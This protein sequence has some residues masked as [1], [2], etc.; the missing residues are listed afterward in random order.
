MASKSWLL[1]LKG[2]KQ[3]SPR[4]RLARM[5]P[6]KIVNMVENQHARGCFRENAWAP[7]NYNVK[8]FWKIIFNSKT[9]VLFQWLLVNNEKIYLIPYLPLWPDSK[10]P[11]VPAQNRDTFWAWQ[12]GLP[13]PEMLPDPF[14]TQFI[15][16]ALLHKTAINILSV[17]T[18]KKYSQIFFFEENEE[19]KQH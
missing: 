7:R 3:G 18:F 6:A 9:L 8:L 5:L 15:P 16:V 12:P 14:L 2:V 11:H 13:G 4:R 19:R 17:F 10:P 1:F